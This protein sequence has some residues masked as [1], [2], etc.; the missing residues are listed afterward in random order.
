[1]QSPLDE[2]DPFIF[3][4][5]T[6]KGMMLCLPILFSEMTFC[7]VWGNGLTYFVPSN[8]GLLDPAMQASD[9]VKFQSL[10]Q[11]LDFRYQALANGVA[12]HAEER[13]AEIEKEKLEKASAVV[14]SWFWSTGL[15][16]A[17][18]QWVIIPLWALVTEGRRWTCS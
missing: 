14:A 8:I 12:V 1:M 13:R 11:T 6:I 3:F 15:L 16:L 10:T 18:T 2:V 4:V 9:P 5:E 17:K 7:L